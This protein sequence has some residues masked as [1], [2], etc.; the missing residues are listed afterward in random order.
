MPSGSVELAFR[1]QDMLALPVSL[2]WTSLEKDAPSPLPAGDRALEGGV[3]AAT[4][5]VKQ[6]GRPRAL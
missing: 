4:Q 1:S 3:L 5:I 2:I 6:S